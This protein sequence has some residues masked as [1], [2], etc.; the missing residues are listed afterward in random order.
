MAGVENE[1][2]NY[3]P[4]AAVPQHIWDIWAEDGITPDNLPSPDEFKPL[5][6]EPKPDSEWEHKGFRG[7]VAKLLF[8]RGLWKKA[9]RFSA[10]G[11]LGRP[12]VCTRYPCE[13]KFYE[14]HGCG[15]IFCRECAQQQRAALFA[16]YL[17]VILSVVRAL[18]V[19]PDGEFTIPLGWMLARVTFSLRSDGSKIT[20]Q[21]VK[22]FNSSVR[23]TMRKSVGSRN[24]Y[25]MLF[26]DEVGFEKRG[27]I[28]ER[29]AG[30]LNLHGHGLYF[31][32]RLDWWKTR[33][34]WKEETEKRFGVESYGFYI[35]PIR[36]FAEDPERAVRHALN[37]MLKYVSKPPAVTA[38]R[39]ASLIA[40]FDGARRVHAL[41][42]FYGK[43]PKREKKNCPC[44]KC[45]AMG[46]PLEK[47]GVVSFEGRTLP[48]GGR[49]PRLVS[50]EELQRDGYELLR[51]AR[52]AFV[53]THD[54]S[55][56]DSLGRPP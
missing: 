12:G 6:L 4:G 24:G 25:G 19:T 36:W 49:I 15:V 44:P 8:G 42:L 48:N 21:I 56:E 43:K 13:H 23:V 20:P 54:F 39:L 37:H 31:G 26:V 22:K 46:I 14:L 5:D 53:L 32:P 47:G 17:G 30:G 38:E 51:D 16:D 50:I 40:A 34:I 41:G 9:A 11:Q 7:Q 29:K 28:R 3:V 52:R 1:I 33:D 10:C 35:T 18:R 45:R 2:L 27:H 55:R